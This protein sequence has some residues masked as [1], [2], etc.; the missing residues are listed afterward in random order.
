MGPKTCHPFIIAQLTRGNVLAL[1]RQTINV[2]NV[3]DV[4]KAVLGA[5]R[6]QRY[7]APIALCGHNLSLEQ[8][9]QQV[10]TLAGRR[11]PELLVSSAAGK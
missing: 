6:N 5:Y 7:G 8:L 2:I 10:A 3:R 1:A 4:A 11:A 9:A